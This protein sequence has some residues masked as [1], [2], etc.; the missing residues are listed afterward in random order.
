VLVRLAGAEAA[1]QASEAA[2]LIA[3]QGLDAH[4]FDDDS[5]LWSEQR[6]GQRSPEGTV[7]R[8]SG[9]QAQLG[10]QMRAAEAVGGTLVGRVAHGLTW[11]RLPAGDEIAAIERLRAELA[12][13]PVV[14][15]D[16]PH[17]VRDGVD[18]WG[19]AG[20][21]PAVELMRRVKERF[22]PAGA[23]NRHKFVGGI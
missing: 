18:A 5:W 19:V 11:I 20:D 3:R 17:G 15:L 14:V 21:S 1:A 22:D 10:D 13:S 2:E 6:A 12:P 16:A 4:T 7:V 8:V 9:T 23:C